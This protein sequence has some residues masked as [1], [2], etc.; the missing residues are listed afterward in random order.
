M[1]SIDLFSI[2]LSSGSW[3]LCDLFMD[4]KKICQTVLTKTQYIQRVA[5]KNTTTKRILSI[6]LNHHAYIE[7]TLPTMCHK[8]EHIIFPN[9]THSFWFNS[10]ARHTNWPTCGPTM[11]FFLTKR[12]SPPISTLVQ[13][14]LYGGSSTICRTRNSTRYARTFTPVPCVVA[15]WKSVSSH[16]APTSSSASTRRWTIVPWNAPKRL[17]RSKENTSPSSRLW[18]ISEAPTACGSSVRSTNSMSP[19]IVFTS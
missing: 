15:A 5:S 12:S 17:P 1:V 8:R 18:R 10:Q 2:N 11:E 19:A 14:H 4:S 6:P 7:T 13:T 9:R 3:I 16:T